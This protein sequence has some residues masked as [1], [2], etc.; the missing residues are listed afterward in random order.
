MRDQAQTGEKPL[1]LRLRLPPPSP[2]S[3]HSAPP[4]SLDFAEAVVEV[5]AA[6]FD[7]LGASPGYLNEEELPVQPVRINLQ[8]L[9]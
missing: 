7:L 4:M 6:D 5:V 1:G 3:R 9:S 2:L 8:L